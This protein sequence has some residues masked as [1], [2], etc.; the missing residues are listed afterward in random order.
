[1]AEHRVSSE[2][3]QSSILSKNGNLVNFTN[4]HIVIIHYGYYLVAGRHKVKFGV[5]IV[6][7]AGLV[8]HI[9]AWAL[10]TTLHGAE[11]NH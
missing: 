2:I 6:F 7:T 9:C 10:A 3:C 1:M 8:L 4:L 11:W 5:S